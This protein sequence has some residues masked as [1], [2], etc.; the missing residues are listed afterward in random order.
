[1]DFVY[2][3]DLDFLGIVPRTLAGMPGIVAGPV[4]HGSLNHLISNT[5]PLLFLGS[6]L[7]FFYESIGR[8]VFFQ[9]YFIPNLLVW[10]LARPANHIGASGLVYG[11]SFFLIVFGLV[12][13]DFLSLTIS[14]VVLF[15]YGGL[16]Y[17]VFTMDPRVSWEAHVAGALVGTVSALNLSRK[18]R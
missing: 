12:R 11:L 1:M 5:L 7:F 17:G 13:R 15:L 10:L 2:G 8:R 4:I 16:L 3:I 14:A 6:V 9:I 18:F